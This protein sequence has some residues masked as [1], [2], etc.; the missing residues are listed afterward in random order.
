MRRALVRLSQHA[1]VLGCLR[2]ESNTHVRAMGFSTAFPQRHARWRSE[3]M[4]HVHEHC[5]HRLAFARKRARI[6]CPSRLTSPSD[7]R[8]VPRNP[9]AS[10]SSRKPIVKSPLMAYSPH[11]L[12]IDVG[13]GDGWLLRRRRRLSVARD[14]RSVLGRLSLE[15]RPLHRHHGLRRGDSSPTS[16]RRCW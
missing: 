16:P 9:L 13:V 8:S 5:R 11:V 7:K 1:V 14:R 12:G 15:H 2:T 3:V 4:H 10:V 6:C